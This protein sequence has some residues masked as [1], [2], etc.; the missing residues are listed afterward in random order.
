MTRISTPTSGQ[1]SG[2]GLLALRDDGP[3]CD[4]PS[5]PLSPIGKANKSSR[6]PQGIPGSAKAQS[7]ANSVDRDRKGKGKAME[8]QE[9]LWEDVQENGWDCPQV[10]KY[11]YDREDEQE[12]VFPFAFR[13]PVAKPV[14]YAHPGPA[15]TSKSFSFTYTQTG[16]DAHNTHAST[17]RIST[18]RPA[19]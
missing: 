14:E 8:V 12:A 3:E 10:D 19:A 17:S 4:A 1:A 13:P 16:D 6:S 15:S 9:Y 18:V 5:K 7:R 11:K 2:W